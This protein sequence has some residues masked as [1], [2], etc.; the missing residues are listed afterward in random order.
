V[1]PRNHIKYSEYGFEIITHNAALNT[2]N[3]YQFIQGNEYSS[4]I[5]GCYS[6]VPDTLNCRAN[7]LD[8]LEINNENCSINF[9]RLYYSEHSEARKGITESFYPQAFWR[10]QQKVGKLLS[11]SQGPDLF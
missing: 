10:R 6:L 11:S 4:P 5:E 9:A 7:P 8:P 3:D 1:I 2:I